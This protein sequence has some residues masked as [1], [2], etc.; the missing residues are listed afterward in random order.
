[1]PRLLLL[2]VSVALSV[3]VAHAAPTTYSVDDLDVEFVVPL[4][5]GSHDGTIEQITG[6]LT[7][8]PGDLARTH[9]TLVA[10]IASFDTG[11][12]KRDCH[13]RESLGIQ[14]EVG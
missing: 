13:L 6:S 5:L 14:I 8:T 1:M 12:G 2:L 9:G 10:P 11:N 7:I 3:P 4:T